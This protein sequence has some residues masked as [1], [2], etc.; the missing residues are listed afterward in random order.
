M[1]GWNRYRFSKTSNSGPV[2]QQETHDHP[3]EKPTTPTP[4]RWRPNPVSESRGPWQ[5]VHREIQGIAIPNPV[6][7][8]AVSPNKSDLDG[9]R[10]APS[11]TAASAISAISTTRGQVSFKMNPYREHLE[12]IGSLSVDLDKLADC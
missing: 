6:F 9:S 8:P 2:G 12:S 7:S 1:Q 5:A 10:T 4:R 3:T 11:R